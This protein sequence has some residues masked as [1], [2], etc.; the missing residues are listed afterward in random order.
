MIQIYV[1]SL[2]CKN[3]EFFVRKPIWSRTEAFDNQGL[4]VFHVETREAARSS[5]VIFELLKVWKND[6]VKKV[7]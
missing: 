6:C 3:L 1:R 5:G 4:T 7:G 2:K